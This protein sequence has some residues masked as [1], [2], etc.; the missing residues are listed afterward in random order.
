MKRRNFSQILVNN[1]DAVP[2]LHFVLKPILDNVFVSKTIDALIVLIALIALIG[3][4]K[5]FLEPKDAD[6]ASR[7]L[8]F[9]VDFGHVFLSLLFC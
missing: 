8:W 3:K 5:H 1:H 6:A 4:N 9:R 2:N 7:E